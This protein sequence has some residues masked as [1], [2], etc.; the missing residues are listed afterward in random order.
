M[1]YYATIKNIQ[2]FSKLGNL[3]KRGISSPDKRICTKKN[4]QLT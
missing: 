2:I 4:L 1:G 3:A